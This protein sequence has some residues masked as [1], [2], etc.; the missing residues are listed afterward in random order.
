MSPYDQRCLYIITEKNHI[1]MYN[2]RMCSHYILVS[3]GWCAEPMWLNETDLII[4]T[5]V[6]ISDIC[7]AW[8][9]TY[10]K[11]NSVLYRHVRMHKLGKIFYFK[12]ITQRSVRTTFLMSNIYFITLLSSKMRLECTVF[13]I[14]QYSTEN[15]PSIYAEGF[16]L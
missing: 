2:D 15:E 9:Y 6:F 3:G 14:Y 7:H 13:I 11:R 1:I 4:I 16:F 12:N 5:E 10:F 8:K